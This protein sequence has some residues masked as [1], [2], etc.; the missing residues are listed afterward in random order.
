MK[1]RK[2]YFTNQPSSSNLIKTFRNTVISLSL[3]LAVIYCQAQ[4]T[5]PEYGHAFL[6]DE[7]AS[8]HINLSQESLD[9]ILLSDSAFSNYEHEATFIYESSVLTDTVENIGFRLRGNTSRLADKK[10]FKV[11]FNSF[12]SGNSWL[13]LKKLNLN[14]EHNDVSIMRSKLCW[15]MLREAGLVS[16]RTSYVKLYVNDEYKGLYLNVEH[17]NDDF[18]ENR[19]SEGDGNVYK[20]I[21]PSDLNYNG[22][23]AGNYTN[24]GYEL[25]TNEWSPSQFEDLAEFITVLNQTNDENLICSL[26]EVFN[27]REY[28]KHLAAEV[29]LGHWDGHVFNK[30]NFYLYSNAAQGRIEWIPYDLDNTLG[31]DF[32]G[33]NWGN[34]NIYNWSSNEYRPLYERLLQNETWREI[35]SFEL[36]RLI[37]NYF[38]ETA[39][40]TKINTWRNLVSEHVE[41][42]IY[43]TMDYGFSHSDFLAS[44]ETTWGNHVSYGILEYVELRAAS[45]LFQLEAINE[46]SGVHFLTDSSPI[47]SESSISFNAYTDEN[48]EAAVDLLYSVDGT[49]WITAEMSWNEESY[50]V[51]IPLTDDASM[52]DY[53]VSYSDGTLEYIYPCQP[54]TIPLANSSSAV[55]INELMSNNEA[56]ILDDTDQAED[57]VELYNTSAVEWLGNLY[58]TDEADFPNKWRIP[59]FTLDES[60]H[61]L[62]W[63]DNDPE[64]GAL[65]TN[66]RLNNGGDQ[67]YV[68]EAFEEGYKLVDH[69]EFNNLEDDTSLGRNGDGADEWI[70][71]NDPTPNAPNLILGISEEA[72]IHMQV[73][74]NP[75]VD[76]IHL[77]QHTEWFLRNGLGELIST[78]NSSEIDLSQLPAGIYILRVLSRDV[79]VIKL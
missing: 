59:G 46:L 38:N 2:V 9:L 77:P 16:C 62:F 60:D 69:I 44:D 20:C 14:G 12:S 28:L 19:F 23:S 68:F 65:H 76:I 30:N 10:S 48:T 71:F 11:S 27:V 66:F 32:F 18:V 34:R 36:N 54:R 6:Q 74:P 39:F 55:V 31:I 35:Y 72:Q 42:D 41:N 43:Y 57:W 70:T 63:C 33:E 52:M 64:E 56:V 61:V 13:G 37:E 21:Y 79:R 1:N 7:V 75:T 49:E 3:V 51:E 4:I 67:V 17:V 47:I 78:G 50:E 15:D 73:Y 58:L 5:Q 24:E 26:P 45:A 22:S 25:Q 40:A 53:Y 29:L 8:V